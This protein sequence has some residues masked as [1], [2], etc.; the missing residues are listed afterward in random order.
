[1]QEG[2]GWVISVGTSFRRTLFLTVSACAISGLLLTRAQDHEEREEELG[3]EH[4]ECVFLGA[5]EKFSKTGLNAAAR[6]R[7][8]RGSLTEEVAGKLPHRQFAAMSMTAASASTE[9]RE[10]DKSGTIDRHIFGG[11]ERAGVTPAQRTTDWEFIRRVT[12]DLTGRVPAPERALSFITD[13]APDK[14]ARLVEELLART[15]WVDKW[16]TYFGDL[17]RNT[18][19]INSQG[20][21]R[22]EQGRNA[23]YR[24]IK[25]SLA[26]NKPSDQMAR[27]LISARGDNSWEQGELNWMVGGRVTGGPN[28]DIWDQQAANIA[29]TF[30]GMSHMNCVLCHNGRG[31]L[32]SLSLWG[33]TATRYSSWQLASFLSH[34]ELRINRTV[35]N[36]PY[37]WSVLDDT[38]FRTDYALNTT[39]GNRPARQPIGTERN[40]R[41]VYPFSGRGPNPGENYRDA[42]AREITADVQFAR[43]SVNYIWKEFFGIGLV[44]PVNQFDLARLDPD[45]PP[46]E[47]W[48]LQPANARL[49]NDLAQD[50]IN[51]KF[52][53]KAL[54]RQIATSEAYQLSARYEGTWKP[55]WEKLFARKLVRR[56][57]AEEIHD[58]IVE[59]S[60]LLPAYN[61]NELGRIQ[62]AMQLPEPRNMPR[63]GPIVFLDNFLRG[64]REDEDRRTDGS[65]QQ[66]LGL[67]NDNFVMS[68]VR[69]TG[70]AAA[71]GLLARNINKTDDELVNTLFLTVLT[72]FPNE[73]EKAAALTSFRAGN[74]TQ[75]AE[76]LLWS[77]YNK[78]DFF[79]NY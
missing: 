29:D 23:F 48:A 26:A 51:S 15:E 3:V 42:L 79:F 1:M 38:R 16:T 4:A 53:L 52:D 60:G 24:W 10:L 11:L 78:V 77:L 47:P 30:L 25:N 62:W 28:Q 27:E 22:Y 69:A 72:R 44:E 9:T 18:E 20:T 39:T 19:R 63:G 41:P 56:L 32:D 74:R 2:R 5:P 49:L 37:Y 8:A 17:F 31:H 73:A 13:G 59:T 64:N 45:N 7:F 35:Q 12:L 61:V 76:H 55:E 58:A 40:I 70:A 21:I 46:A 71:G 33:K 68:R 50:F 57:W 75:K 36:Q 6:D 54:M 67:M 66:A 14:R 34:T 65:A 43:A